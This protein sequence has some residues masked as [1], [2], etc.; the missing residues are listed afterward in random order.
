M[1]VN[2]DVDDDC[3][4]SDESERKG[5][6]KR[7]CRRISMSIVRSEIFG[8]GI[9]VQRPYDELPSVPGEAELVSERVKG[10]CNALDP[11]SY[12]STL[13]ISICIPHCNLEDVYGQCISLLFCSFAL[14]P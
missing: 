11:E 9:Q 4:G 7:R 14:L 5:K 2:V 10:V 1:V 12:V 3:K 6:G 8:R 13:S